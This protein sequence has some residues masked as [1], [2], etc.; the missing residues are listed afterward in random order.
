MAVRPVVHAPHVDP[1]RFH[2]VD[3]DIS[4]GRIRHSPD[5]WL[6]SLR[7]RR[8]QWT[9]LPDVS[10]ILPT[11]GFRVSDHGASNGHLSRTYPPFSRL[12]A[13]ESPITAPAMDISPGRI[14]HSPDSWLSSL[15]SR[16]QQ[17]TSL[18]DVSAILPTL[19]FRVSDHGASNGH[20]SRTYPPFSRLLAF[21]SPITAPA[22]DISPGRI[23]HSPG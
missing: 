19:G 17:W 14:R 4:P 3:M 22:M 10:A 11:L 5:S 2:A 9:S 1:E 12:L 7:S 21:E 13:F 6:S 20:L 8:Q 16:R 23:R 18:P 15:R